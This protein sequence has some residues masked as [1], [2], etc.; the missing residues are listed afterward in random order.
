MNSDVT[1]GAV[2]VLTN[3][4]S[5]ETVIASVTVAVAVGVTVLNMVVKPDCADELSEGAPPEGSTTMVPGRSENAIVMSPSLAVTVMIPPPVSV[6]AADVRVLLG[7]DVI[8][9]VSVSVLLPVTLAISEV[10]VGISDVILAVSELVTDSDATLLVSV[11][12]SD[13]GREVS[14]EVGAAVDSLATSDE[15]T[16]MLVVVGESVVVDA[17]VDASVSV[18]DAATSLVELD[19]ASVGALDDAGTEGALS[20]GSYASTRQYVSRI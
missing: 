18:V 15:E 10:E 19:V 7:A 2:K 8:V 9:A 16:G 11:E 17:T 12:E 14:D 20:V 6:V 4:S 13:V 1:P 3:V 5:I